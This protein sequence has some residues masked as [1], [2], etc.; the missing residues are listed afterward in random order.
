MTKD[1]WSK[2]EQIAGYRGERRDPTHEAGPKI[3]TK[4]VPEE[5][6]RGKRAPQEGSGVVIGS[7]AGAGGGG[8]P[9]DYDDDPSGGG[10]KPRTKL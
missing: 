9:E 10:G 1:I 6:S 3:R 5:E 8:S 2:P 7:G 4:G